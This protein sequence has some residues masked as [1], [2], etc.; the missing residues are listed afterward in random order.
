MLVVTTPTGQIGR[1]VLAQLVAAGEPVRAVARD[2]TR[3]EPES[4]A[5]AEVVEGSIDD[6]A[7]LGKALDGAEAVFWCIPPNPRLSDVREYYLGF[8]RPFA[9]ALAGSSIRRVVFVSS[10]G[11]GRANNAGPISATFAVEELLEGTG[12]H[13]RALRCGSFMEN[14]LHQVEPI[15]H[16]GMFFY[17]IAG[18]FQMP[19]CAARDIAGTAVRL[20]LDRSW[21]GQGGVAVQ[22]DAR[23]TRPERGFRSRSGRHVPGDRRGDSRRRSE[24]ARIDDSDYVRGMVR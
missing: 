2:R 8:S 23:R 12:V 5:K 22:G 4:L 21:T 13:L 15:K 9:A 17:P 6:P 7:T 18:D 3:I 20:L 14:M 11:R 1:H 24:D 16:Q 19:V 10:G